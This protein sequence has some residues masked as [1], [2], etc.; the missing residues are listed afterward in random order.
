MPVRK[1]LK[2][3]LTNWLGGKQFY[4]QNDFQNWREAQQKTNTAF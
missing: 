2:T 3:A 1:N 4:S